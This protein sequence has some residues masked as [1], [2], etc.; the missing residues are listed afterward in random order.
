[1]RRKV[2]LIAG[3]WI[4]QPYGWSS[5]NLAGEYVL[6]V[7]SGKPEAT[8]EIKGQV[9]AAECRDFVVHRLEERVATTEA[10]P[11]E[12]RAKLQAAG[13]SYQSDHQTGSPDS[14]PPQARASDDPPDG[15]CTVER[16]AGTYRSI[17]GDITCKPVGSRLE[18]CYG[19][20]SC[21]KMLHLGITPNGQSLAGEWE[22]RGRQKGPAEFALTNTC[23]LSDG[24]WG[25]AASRMNHW[26]VV[27]RK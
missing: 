14:A 16:I 26:K 1:M 4:R 24:R 5:L 10:M 18:C 2:K 9:S 15:Q 11:L 22:H 21:Q 27:G 25:F 20:A 6:G 23:E 19:G 12:L 3:P 17:A 7:G 13:Y 8:G